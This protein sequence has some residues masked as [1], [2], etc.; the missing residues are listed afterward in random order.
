MSYAVRDELI[1]ESAWCRVK[2]KSEV[3]RAKN[4]L[5]IAKE[6]F[7]DLSVTTTP[8]PSRWPLMRTA[9]PAYIVYDS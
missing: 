4:K 6:H 9:L 2:N 8:S 3:S 5:A 7:K 1:E